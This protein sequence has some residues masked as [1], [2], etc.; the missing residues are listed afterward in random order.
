MSSLLT[1][2][3]NNGVLALNIMCK[4]FDLADSVTA[5]ISADHNL[6]ILDLDDYSKNDVR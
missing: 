6:I 5:L 2:D 4:F 1:R 3:L